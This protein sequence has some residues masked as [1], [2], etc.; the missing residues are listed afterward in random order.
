MPDGLQTIVGNNGIRL[1]EVENVRE[2]Q[3]VEHY[4]K[5]QKFYF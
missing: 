5:I 1:S 4:I 2:W 3:S